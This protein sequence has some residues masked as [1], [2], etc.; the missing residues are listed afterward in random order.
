[1]IQWLVGTEEGPNTFWGKTVFPSLSVAQKHKECV[2]REKRGRVEV[3]LGLREGPNT[4]WNDFDPNFE[5]VEYLL[6]DLPPAD[7][8]AVLRVKP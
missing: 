2:Y 8:R 3:L 6:K 5:T 7:D 1:M 4:K